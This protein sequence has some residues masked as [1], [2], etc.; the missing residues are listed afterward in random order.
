MKKLIKFALALCVPLLAVFG[1]YDYYMTLPIEGSYETGP[2]DHPKVNTLELKATL[3]KL[4]TSTLEAMKHSGMEVLKWQDM[5]SRVSSNVISELIPESDP[6]FVR[7][8]YP[9]D[10]VFDPDTQSLYYYHSH[11]P[12]EHGHFHLFFCDKE[13]LSKHQPLT[14]FGKKNS[15][16]HLFAISIHPDGTP[17]GL[18]T[19]N[20]WITPKEWWYSAESINDF[21]DHFEITHAYPSFPTNQWVNHMVNLFKPQIKELLIQRDQV[22]AETGLPLEKALRNRKMDLLSET[23]IS[24][25]SQMEAIEEILKERASTQQ[26]TQ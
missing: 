20:L 25:E 16:V 2:V 7:E 10:E 3:S 22:L 21:V 13:I 6:F 17:I 18:F 4:D 14:N 19:T 9:Y 15:S 23:S 24:I 26:L 5:L 1:V 8:H 11:R 12:G